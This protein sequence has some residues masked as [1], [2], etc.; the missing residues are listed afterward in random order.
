M[1]LTRFLNIYYPV[2]SLILLHMTKGS[3]K[4][5]ITLVLIMPK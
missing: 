2:L 5:E 3:G 1:P 4:Y